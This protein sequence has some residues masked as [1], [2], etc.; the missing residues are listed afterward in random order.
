MNTISQCV[1]QLDRATTGAELH[2]LA[3]ELYPWCRSITGDGVRHTLQRLAREIPLT[4]HEVASGTAVLDWTVPP[5]WTLR[6]AWIKTSSG[7]K[8]VDFKECNL[9]VVSYS[10]PV[11]KHL[12]LDEL[13]PRLHSRPDWPDVVP[14]RTSYYQPDW[15]FCMT[16]SAKQALRPDTYEVF[17]EAELQ[18]GHLTY[19]EWVLPGTTPDEMLFSTHICH[20][21]LANDNLSGIV[22]ATRLA[23]LLQSVEHKLTYRFIFVPGTIGAITWLAR[24]ADAMPPIRHGLVLACLGDAGGPTYKRSRAGDQVIDRAVQLVLS[25]YDPPGDIRD[26]SPYG[27]DERQ[28]G[29]PGFNLP[30]GLLMRSPYG[31]FPEYHTS[32]DNLDFI[33]PPAL[34]D[35]LHVLL[36]VLEV[37]EGNAT[38]QNLQPYGEPQLGRRGLYDQLGGANDARLEQQALL[39]VL[40]Q[41]DGNHSLLD[42]AERS[43]LSFPLIAQA[44]A[45]LQQSGLLRQGGE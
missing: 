45:R 30:V 6:D 17:I 43:S 37:L 19:G 1:Q 13:L 42:I 25:Q 33:R 32:A 31:E 39:W 14:Y 8:V 15:G 2:A 18:P 4:V 16:E 21:S 38:F 12:S 35:S 44:A 20:P 26:F 27:Y 3:A 10:Q 23:A 24:Q 36:Q 7:Q 41:S 22:V 11:H 28:F 9:H 5:E 34:A 29:S 40:N